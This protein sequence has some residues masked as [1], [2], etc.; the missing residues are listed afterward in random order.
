MHPLEFLEAQA[1]IEYRA[2]GA[3]STSTIAR[4]QDLGADAEAIEADIIEQENE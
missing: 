1:R 3:V 4:L 2:N